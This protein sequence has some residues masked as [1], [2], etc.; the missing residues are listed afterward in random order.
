MTKKGQLELGLDFCGLWR[1]GRGEEHEFLMQV[2]KWRFG[3]SFHTHEGVRHDKLWL[4]AEV[5]KYTEGMIYPKVFEIVL[6]KKDFRFVPDTV[7]DERCLYHGKKKKVQLLVGFSGDI[8][9]PSPLTE[10]PRAER[11]Q[12]IDEARAMMKQNPYVSLDGLPR[13]DGVNPL[14][15]GDPAIAQSITACEKK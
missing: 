12:T 11:A 15:D 7:Y 14:T 10:M 6:P 13:V 8:Y 4:R 1:Q 3:C 9:G 5:I 2:V